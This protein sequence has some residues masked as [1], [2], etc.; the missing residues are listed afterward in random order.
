MYEAG[1]LRAYCDA[2]LASLIPGMAALIVARE[3]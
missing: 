1:T 2:V 3:T